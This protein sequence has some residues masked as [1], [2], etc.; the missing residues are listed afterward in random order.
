M[1]AWYIFSALGFYP[2][3][4]GSNEYVIGSPCVSEVIINLKNGRKFK[5]ISRNFYEENIYINEVGLNGK[6]IGRSF[7]TYEE[8]INGGELRFLIWGK[9]NNNRAGYKDSRLIL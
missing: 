4:P 5:I 1:S 6:N 8:I 7:I 2:V 9:P 3:A